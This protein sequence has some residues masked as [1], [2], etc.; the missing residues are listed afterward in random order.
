[1]RRLYWIAAALVAAPRPAAP[2]PTPAVGML[3]LR[4][5]AGDTATDTAAIDRFAGTYTQTRPGASTTQTLVLVLSRNQICTLTTTSLDRNSRPVR[6]EGTWTTDGRSLTVFLK[7]ANGQSERNEITFE[8][9]GDQLVA[10][11]YDRNRYG[12]A[13]LTLERPQARTRTPPKVPVEGS[14]VEE[15]PGAD[16]PQKLTLVLN[17][18]KSCTLTTEFVGSNR[19][20]VVETGTWRYRGGWVTVIFT[21]AN[22][23]HEDNVIK[24]QR[25]GQDLLSVDFDR[26]RYGASGLT[27]K[28]QP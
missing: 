27:M 11:R 28:K 3:A 26:S 23:R 6:E 10:T 1:M 8:P 2:Y 4:Q 18:N 21:K 9:R 12:S 25:R 24:F 19:Q 5:P 17:L 16:Y 14:Y 13:G 15:R 20:P 7:E 22:G